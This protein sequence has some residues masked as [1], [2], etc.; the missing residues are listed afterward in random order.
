MLKRKRAWAHG[1]WISGLLFLACSETDVK[2]VGDIAGRAGGGSG[3]SMAHS[4]TGGAA[5]SPVACATEA[6]VLQALPGKACAK[7]GELCT[8]PA[9]PCEH[10]Y[11]VKCVA[12]AWDRLT[13]LTAP[14]PEGGAGQGGA[15]GASNAP[16]CGQ[17][18]GLTEEACKGAVGC[19]PRYGEPWPGE[20][21]AMPE[22]AGCA[23]GCC[24]GDCE[25]W[26][27]TEACA[28]PSD[29]SSECWTLSSPPAPAGWVLLSEVNGCDEFPQ[30]NP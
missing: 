18:E 15:A 4:G 7:E 27:Q 19:L 21:G 10:N 5:P 28:A 1:V 13:G 23:T 2:D 14:C 6:A 20:L 16:E 22:Y 30:C 24:S 11:S 8:D 25:G 12:G 26:P 3:G 17:C 9:P 29:S